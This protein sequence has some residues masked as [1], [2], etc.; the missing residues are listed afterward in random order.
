[1]K[2]KFLAILLTLCMVLSL[3]PANTVQAAGSYNT[4]LEPNHVR[5]K[6]NVYDWDEKVSNDVNVPVSNVNINVSR[7]AT[8]KGNTY[9]SGTING[10]ITLSTSDEN[11]VAYVDCN[12]RD[13]GSGRPVLY[14]NGTNNKNNVM[15]D[16]WAAWPYQMHFK[17]QSASSG[18]SI[19]YS[20]PYSVQWIAGNQGLLDPYTPQERATGE[21][22]DGHKLGADPYGDYFSFHNDSAKLGSYGEFNIY[23]KAAKVSVTFENNHIKDFDAAKYP[24]QRVKAGECFIKPA[25]PVHDSGDTSI[26]FRG[27]KNKATGEI[28]DFSK[29][30]SED[31]TLVPI[32]YNPNVAGYVHL[33]SFLW[34]HD[35]NNGSYGSG[36]TDT[37]VNDLKYIVEYYD[38]AVATTTK[39]NKLCEVTVDQNGKAD[40]TITSDMLAELKA[41]Y[42]SIKDLPVENNKPHRVAIDIGPDVIDEGWHTTS[43]SKNTYAW[44][45]IQYDKTY[46][47]GAGVNGV[48][49]MKVNT[50]GAGSYNSIRDDNEWVQGKNGEVSH[51]VIGNVEYGT[52]VNHVPWLTDDMLEN[53]FEIYW[54]VYVTPSMVVHF[55]LDG[56]SGAG[57]YSDQKFDPINSLPGT[58]QQ[59][60]YKAKKP[61][62]DP[63]RKAEEKFV[64][65]YRVIGKDAENE[66]I[67]EGV[68]WDF[69]NRLV[70]KSMTL[71]AVY[72]NRTYNVVF[73]PANGQQTQSKSYIAG[74][75]PAWTGPDP[76]KN[77][78]KKYTYEFEKWVETK[79]ISKDSDY[80]FKDV[81]DIDH[82]ARVIYDDI[83]DVNPVTVKADFADETIYTA[84]YKATPI[85]YTVT[86]D[87]NGGK[88][89]GSD[90]FEPQDYNFDTGVTLHDGEPVKEHYKFIGWELKE[91]DGNWENKTYEKGEK[92]TGK[93]G[94]TTLIAKFA[95]LY[96][97]KLNF[98]KNTTDTVSDMPENI[99][100]T[101]WIE[102]STYEMTWEKVPTRTNYTFLGWSTSKGGEVVV[103]PDAKAYTM[104]GTAAAL[105]E[106][107]L[108][109]L[110]KANE[111][112]YT[113]KYLEEGT[114]KE[115]YEEKTDKA[116]IGSTVNEDAVP[117]GGY[118]L[119][120]ETPQSLEI[121]ED[122]NENVIVFYYKELLGD[123]TIRKSGCSDADAAKGQSFIFHVTST[124]LEN[125]EHAPIDMY[126]TVQG[127]G[128]ITVKDLP[129]GTYK[130]EEVETWSW[131]YK[132]DGPKDV[133]LDKNG[134]SAEIKNT[135]EN[136]KWFSG[137]ASA[138]NTASGRQTE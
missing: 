32:W 61:A 27:W 38:Q 116:M 106:E 58:E 26:E 62:N 133:K 137:S 60:K 15:F 40:F 120:S 21:H 18:Y 88:A 93:Y 7:I 104:T 68:S 95:P 35:A 49:T 130:V 97:Y 41:F 23:V 121:S 84:Q 76:V 63:N 19:D 34:D 31:V 55:D 103:G 66:D 1:M 110:W 89:E 118:E 107:T 22:N 12:V 115:L 117:I 114:E 102:D 29:P 30:A 45:W 8:E 78:D 46:E 81:Y 96:K 94:D 90:T 122:E 100:A 83:S 72:A 25:D 125:K 112:K 127:N 9:D 39:W 134:N 54:T 86:Y 132:A 36:R 111:A 6:V 82:T 79:G 135:R 42:E 70:T 59:Q 2:K 20:S 113:V 65:W 138:I 44:D 57:D 10:F 69:A 136:G 129:T 80:V 43:D 11:G 124:S 105:K 3:V 53:G 87:L 52:N 85:D 56:G 75:T 128:S 73:D 74:G 50:E 16:G 17:F 33:D 24:Q 28:F 14:L 126:V 64:G 5:I 109:A 47:H 99:P 131:R 98:D 13:L 37:T 67:L 77:S 48:R 119:V 92:V 108:Y 51:P 91:T 101:D 71:K 4:E 123:L